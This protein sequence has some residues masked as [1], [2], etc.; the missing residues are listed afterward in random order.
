MLQ[1][2][3]DARHIDPENLTVEEKRK[4]IQQ[5]ETIHSYGV[6]HN[7]IAPRNILL[8]P[9][10]QRFFFIDFGLSEFV[11]TKSKKIYKEKK[12]LNKLLQI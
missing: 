11:G 7:D 3:E 9:K 5:L 8:E 4:I 1:L 2:I 6:L 10:S 12:K